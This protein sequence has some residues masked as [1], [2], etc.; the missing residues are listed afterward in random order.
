MAA[1]RHDSHDRPGDARLQRPSFDRGIS[2]SAPATTEVI[3]FGCR[4]N[5]ADSDSMR[6]L[7]AD[8]GD[9]IIINTC[10]VTGEAVRQ[11]RQAI[12]KAKRANPAA[13][14][15]VTGCAAQIEPETFPAIPEVSRVAR[16][17]VVL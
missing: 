9:T 2:V 6:A 14:V 16:K 7:A 15:I 17:S 4:L 8:A 10:A 13:H 1:G 12:R 5:A 3:T 11:A